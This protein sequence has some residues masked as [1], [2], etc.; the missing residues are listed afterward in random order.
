MINAGLVN[1]LAL[2]PKMENIPRGELEWLVAHGRLEAYNAG[3][4]IAPKGK[5]IEKLWIIL[6]GH[7][8]VQRDRG[9]GSRHVTEWRAGSVT[10][11]LPYSRM[12]G[13]PGDNYLEENSEFLTIHEKD[14]PEMIRQ[15]PVFTTY[16]VH[17]M[18]DRARVFKTSDLQNEKM[19]SLG[20]LAAGLAHEINNPASAIVRGAKQLLD[21]LA[22]TDAASN[23]IG[24]A[25]LSDDLFKSIEQVR[26]SCLAQPTVNVLSPIKQADREE[27][28]ADWLSDHQMDPTYAES[29]ATTTV[30]I[31]LLDKLANMTSDDKL[32]FVLRWIAAGCTTHSLVV[33]ILNASTRIS[34]LVSAVKRFTYMDKSA[35]PELVNIEAGLRDTIRV[36]ASKVKSKGASITIDVEAD[37]PNVYA[38]GS[39]LNQVWLNL[40]D[41][42]LDAI[43]ESGNIKINVRKELDRVVVSIIDDGQGISPELMPRIFD[44]FFTTKP[45]GEG[46]GMGLEITR[47]LV[48]TNHGDI[49]VKSRPG[50]TEFRVSLIVAKTD[51]KG[52]D[53][54]SGINGK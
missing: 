47:R 6:S 14:F 17:S 30:T 18:L 3:T 35:K 29:L 28:I 24:A 8:T 20:K 42:A 48:N 27:M 38:N 1:R 10:G 12:T 19:V 2:L 23:A 41:N 50:Q 44:P 32:P 46:T 53:D 7:I 21:S 16:T 25:G 37:L 54:H 13:P 4:V 51:Q 22:E 36:L 31:D 49:S 34:E 15:C 45:P 40:V 26:S 43:S 52:V 5:R 33:D 39:E 9:T 11:M